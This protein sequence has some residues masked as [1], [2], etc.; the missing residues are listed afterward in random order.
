MSTLGHRYQA[1][2]AEVAFTIQSISKPFVYALVVEDLGL[3]AVAANVGFEPSGEPFNAIS[4]E[5]VT[6]R[7][8]NPMIN[9][10]AIV[11]SAMV[12]G[13]DTV[14]R[15]ERVRR[16][17]SAFAGRSL[18]VDE[19]VCASETLTGHR[20]RA[21]AHLTLAAGRLAT[22]ADEAVEVYFRQ[23]SLLVTTAD[24]AVM[25]ATLANG[26]TNPVTGAQVVGEEVARHTLSLMASC[27]MYD[28]SGEWMLRVGLPAKSGVGGGV[29]AVGPGEFGVGVFSPPLDE[30]G[31]S[32]RG[33]AALTEVS[34]AFDLHLLEHPT[35]PAPP[36]DTAEEGDRHVVRVRGE[37]DFVTVEQLVSHLEAH[38]ERAPTGSI[39]VDLDDVTRVRPV[40]WSLLA[41]TVA[42]LEAHGWAV[43]LHDPHSVLAGLVDR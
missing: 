35:A 3:E 43:D 34:R 2:D 42:D 32:V 27:G 11:T 10:G 37:L 40:G 33:V 18:E 29:V 17:L 26:G 13:P 30:R 22:S 9:A 28:S 25:A 1:G 15:N 24:L 23:C 21:L 19:A 6:G 36:I 12:P 5:P 8:A 38:H 31:N 39:R 16:T 7:P 41:L 20:N 14:A 4:L